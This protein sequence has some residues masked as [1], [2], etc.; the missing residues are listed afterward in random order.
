MACS[1]DPATGTTI[2]VGPPTVSCVPPLLW[3]G[4]RC[5]CQDGS[6]PIGFSGAGA[7]CAVPPPPT[8]VVPPAQCTV[9]VG[10]AAN[11]PGTPTVA[12]PADA[13]CDPGMVAA[14]LAAALARALEAP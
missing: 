10:Y 8:P 6:L 1:T 4:T 9:T 13:A 5:Q 14:L 2:C 3:N 11:A 12:K 7:L